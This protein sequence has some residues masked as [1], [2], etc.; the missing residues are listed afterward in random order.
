MYGL[1]LCF[2]S[3]IQCFLSVYVIIIIPEENWI[4][5]NFP[6]VIVSSPYSSS[7][8]L[9]A[10]HFHQTK[11]TSVSLW[12]LWKEHEISLFN[13]VA[14]RHHNNVMYKN[15]HTRLFIKLSLSLKSTS[16]HLYVIWQDFSVFA[17][18]KFKLSTRNFNKRMAS[19][20][21]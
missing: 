9:H 3:S 6:L 8:S 7:D 21:T 14:E 15:S 16:K 10:S 19:F 13:S 1:N 4:W 20:S 17:S 18:G 5:L 2:S 12:I 11:Y